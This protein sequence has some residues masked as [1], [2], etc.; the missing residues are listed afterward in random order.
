MGFESGGKKD[1]EGGVAMLAAVEDFDEIDELGLCLGPR[2]EAGAR[3]LLKF[4]S[5]PAGVHGGQCLDLS[6]RFF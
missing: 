5:A 3:V 1:S 2:T 4:D 6:L